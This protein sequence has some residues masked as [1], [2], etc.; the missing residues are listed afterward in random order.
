MLCPE[1]H[2]VTSVTLEECIQL[3][4][5]PLFLGGY[6]VYLFTLILIFHIL[7]F[8]SMSHRGKSMSFLLV[9][10]KLKFVV[11]TKGTCI[12]L[13]LKPFTICLISQYPTPTPTHC[14]WR[15]GFLVIL[16]PCRHVPMP[17][18]QLVPLPGTL[19]SQIPI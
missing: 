10:Y 7:A 17:M 11:Q 19:L 3:S 8:M 12:L 14:S 9:T 13:P 5:P 15:H 2:K 16:R 1:R 6:E 4:S 18:H